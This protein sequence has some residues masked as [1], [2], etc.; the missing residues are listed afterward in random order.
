[1]EKKE[2]IFRV[3]PKGSMMACT[4]VGQPEPLIHLIHIS[5]YIYRWFPRN[6]LALHDV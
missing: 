6:M 2:F 3:I 5:V 4:F 1:M